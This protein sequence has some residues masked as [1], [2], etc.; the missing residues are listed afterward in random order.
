M[1]G[2]NGDGDEPDAGADDPDGGP[3]TEVVVCP[4]PVPA[5]S[6]GACDVQTGS[7]EAVLLRGTVLAQGTVFENGSVLYQGTSILCTGCDCAVDPAAADA[8][9]IACADAVISPA[10]I[11]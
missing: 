4:D 11:N 8:T 5:P 9:I 10:L 6:E 7:G 1:P 3:D 2:G